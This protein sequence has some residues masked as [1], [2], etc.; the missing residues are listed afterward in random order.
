MKHFRK[1]SNV[2]MM[3][4]VAISLMFG[5]CKDN[6]VPE[7]V[8]EEVPE[9]VPEEVVI[10][11]TEVAPTSIVK[12]AYLTLTGTN[13]DHVNA[14]RFTDLSVNV[15]VLK[16]NFVSVSATQILVTV[17]ADAPFDKVAVVSEE[18]EVI[19]WSGTLEEKVSAETK[20][21]RAI[22]HYL[23][24]D[25]VAQV[26]EVTASQTQIIVKG[27]YSGTGNYSLCE[28]TPWQDVTLTEVFEYRTAL[29]DAPFSLSFDRFVTR[30]NSTYDRSLS[31]WLIV[32][33]GTKDE[34]ISHARYADNID[35]KQSP[36]S[37]GVLAGKKGAAIW[38]FHPLFQ[39]DL[40]DLKLTCAT[41][42]LT[43]TDLMY[44]TQGDVITHQ[45]A[46]KTWYFNRSGIEALDIVLLEYAKR[47]VVVA[48]IVLIRPAASAADKTIGNLLQH[49]DYASG[50][51]TMPNLSTPESVETYAAALDFVASRYMRN[52]NRYG[53]IH[54]WIIHNEADI[55]YEWTNMGRN[56]AMSVYMDTYVKS[57]RL[58]YNIFR[59]YD[60]NTEVF[61]SFTQSWTQPI[62]SQGYSTVK[63]LNALN[64]YCRAEGDFKWGLA[65]HPYP[66]SITDPK[67]W[68]DAD[69][70]FSMNTKLLT[71]KNLEVVDKWAKTPANQY[72]GTVKR[73][74]WL[75][76][77][78][79][80]SPSYSDKDLEEQAAGCAYA[81]KK[82]NALSGIDCIVWNNW[83][84]NPAEFGLR[85]GL[86]NFDFEPKSAW[87]VYKAADTPEEDAVFEPYKAVIGIS[88]WNII[89]NIYTEAMPN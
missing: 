60:S 9:V 6:D 74:V 5:A 28:V 25:Y 45:Y 75:S 66:Q 77:N 64:D 24:Q 39:Q 15:D 21:A 12:G 20:K 81:W 49:P 79:T 76:E 58:C 19:F 82:L 67:T 22:E 55:G 88:D 53:R 54:H 69:A 44:A 61:G 29:T 7:K 40:D 33:D 11:L 85:L 2:M 63:M 87:Y 18:N 14:V 16:E 48:A 23:V 30:N 50:H 32:K 86:R 71:F 68:L 65:I 36:L 80:N 57:M 78:G 26:T 1:C 84:D 52:D 73:S 27:L 10:T 41:Y 70:T 42:N 13:L 47:N 43:L 72:L 31:K 51:Y 89:Q 37:P 35:A 34:I 4:F 46:G 3:A 83:A 17:P 59:Q 38:A 56:R 62:S 8:P